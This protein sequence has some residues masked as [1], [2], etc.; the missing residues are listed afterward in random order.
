MFFF[1]LHVSDATKSL[2]TY[3]FIKVIVEEIFT[4]N[5]LE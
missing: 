5:H 1:S 2:E 4:D 3:S